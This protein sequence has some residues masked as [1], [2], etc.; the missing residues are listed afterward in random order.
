MNKTIGTDF[1]GKNT[2]SE[3]FAG[4]YGALAKMYIKQAHQ[5]L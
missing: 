3:G 2:V 5:A 4:W 1:T